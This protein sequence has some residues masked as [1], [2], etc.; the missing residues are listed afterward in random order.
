MILPRELGLSLSSMFSEQFNC[1][2][3]YTATFLVVVG[4]ELEKQ[5]YSSTLEPYKHSI[6]HSGC[7]SQYIR[8][9]LSSYYALKYI[10]YAKV[11]SY[12]K[13]IKLIY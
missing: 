6:V 9:R 11:L 10:L 1:C 5:D 13:I 3:A 7:I 4:D 2:Y 8:K 12:H